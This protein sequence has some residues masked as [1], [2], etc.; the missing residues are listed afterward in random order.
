[1]I[2]LITAS[3]LLLTLFMAGDPAVDSGAPAAM[4]CAEAFGEQPAML[5]TAG[6]ATEGDQ[7]PSLGT[8]HTDWPTEWPAWAA[9]AAQV[10]PTPAPQP[11]AWPNVPTLALRSA[12][13]GPTPPPPR[14]RA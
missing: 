9:W 4:A 7:A 8:E 1:M 6:Q 14:A 11:Q 10:V 2:R 5:D 12:H 13:T 3:L